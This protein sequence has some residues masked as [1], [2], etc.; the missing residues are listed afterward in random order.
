LS[1]RDSIVLSS[2]TESAMTCVGDSRHWIY[3]M[4]D[5][6]IAYLL[7]FKIF[8]FFAAMSIASEW[9]KIVLI[10]GIKFTVK[11]FIRLLI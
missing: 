9:L 3:I 8:S 10:N 6:L 4:S 5:V 7:I 2:L 1:I 11:V